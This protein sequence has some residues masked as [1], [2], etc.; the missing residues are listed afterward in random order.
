M[1]L[2]F[3]KKPVLV[4][5][6]ASTGLVATNCYGP[7][8]LTQ[9]L[10]NWN[11]TLGDKYINA[12]LFVALNIVPVYGIV[13]GVDAVVLNSIEFWTGTN[14]MAMN[15]GQSDSKLITDGGKTWR[16]TAKKH[17]F[18]I[19]QIAGPNLG[20]KATLAFNEQTATWSIQSGST[21]IDLAQLTTDGNQAV[22]KGF[23]PTGV[24]LHPV[25]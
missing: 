20:E 6:I 19:E 18:E 16:V 21:S 7:F 1:N 2:S 22:V 10:Y 15:E 5:L 4:L 14:P 13:V 11:G 12:I 9:K 8:R 17:R 25:H 3:F 23:T 24:E